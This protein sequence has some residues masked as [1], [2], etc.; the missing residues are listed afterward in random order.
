M[1]FDMRFPILK[2]GIFVTGIIAA[3]LSPSAFAKEPTLKPTTVRFLCVAPDLQSKFIRLPQ[4]FYVPIPFGFDECPPMAVSIKQ[5]GDTYTPIAFNRNGISPSMVLTGD[6]KGPPA[7]FYFEAFEMPDAA[8]ISHEKMA[9]SHETTPK[10]TSS[11]NNP[12]GPVWHLLAESPKQDGKDHLICLFNPN[13]KAKWY[14]PKS[15]DLDIS[16]EEEVASWAGAG[17]QHVEQSRLCS[18][19]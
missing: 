11:K 15:L 1:K 6:K 7:G 13:P 16:V 8:T 19:W 5:H 12:K 9:D 4:G 17:D 14:P 3:S 18:I 10:S 2:K